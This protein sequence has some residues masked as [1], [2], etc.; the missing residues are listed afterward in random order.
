MKYQEPIIITA[1]LLIILAVPIFIK[2]S[3]LTPVPNKLGLRELISAQYTDSSLFLSEI[4][5]TKVTPATTTVTGLIVPHHL[6]A[7]NIIADTYSYASAGKYQTI[8]LL[9][10]DHFLA[11]K[12]NVSVSDRD[13]STVFGVVSSDQTI[14]QELKKLSFAS[15]A[16]FFYRE[17]GLQAQLPF[18]KYYFPEAKV[19]AITF[20]PSTSVAELN[21]VIKTLEQNLSAN[22]LIVQSTDF[23]H[24]LDPAQAAIKDT[25][26][27]NTIINQGDILKLNQPA[28]I[29]SVA[30]LYIEAKLQQDF[31]KNAP[32]IL[33]HQNSQ[34]YTTEKV[35]SSTSYLAIAYQAPAVAKASGNAEF[36]FVGD[37]MLSR[38][39]GDLMA[40]NNNYDFPF[41]KITPSLQGADLVFGN[42]ESPISNQ[43]Q[44]A[45]H[46]YSFRA[47]PQALSGLKKAGFTV[48][49]VANNHAFD[50]GLAA[51]TDT[52]NNLKQT[53]LKYAGG[54]LDFTEAH[55]G[56][57]QEINGIKITV[58]AYTN[59]LPANEAATDNQAGFANLNTEQMI[60]DIKAAK[61]KSDLVIVSFHWG[62]EY[63]TRS[64][65]SQ[66]EIATTAIQAG[67]DLI[68]GH[69]PHVPQE[70]GEVQGV[71][72]A[73]SLGNFIF[74]QN[75]SKDT[76]TALMLKVS[77]QNK[78][79]VKVEPQTLNFNNNFQ[80]YL[81]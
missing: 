34:V 73:Y 71:T 38:Y 80:P 46:L 51:F 48:L 68:V 43:G 16:D 52:L 30:A 29:D 11:G 76:A 3:R 45:G 55:Q 75:F 21:Q 41:E 72:V 37:I 62:Q 23:S 6:L 63:Q 39:I 69:H 61:A 1:L 18:I 74:D 65:K 47:D 64:N 33:D 67:A 66:Q 50:Y 8:V 42:L 2:E 4:K 49:S 81:K 28:N 15:E 12:S 14:T 54:G 35:T 7:K 79:I 70:I 40:K 25:E 24:Y 57:Y 78:K 56:S 13:F 60:R 19:V 9:S 20:K 53:G 59:L 31:F 36:V 27:I 26:T 22:S 10:P 17:H 5:Q 77:I 32:L 44:S 58:L